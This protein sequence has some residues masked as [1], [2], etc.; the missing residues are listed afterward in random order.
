VLRPRHQAAQAERPELLADAALVHRHAEP[1]LDASLEI[2]PPPAHHPVALGIGTGSE[3]QIPV[4]RMQPRS[5]KLWE[6]LDR[7]GVLANY[8]VVVLDT[9]PALGY[10]TINGLTVLYGRESQLRKLGNPPASQREGPPV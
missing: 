5:W 6:A 9:P 3:F 2:D 4:W 10:L 7:D 8:D 1:G